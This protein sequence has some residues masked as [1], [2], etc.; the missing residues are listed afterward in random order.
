MLSFT[1][2]MVNDPDETVFAGALTPA[3]IFSAGSLPPL[4]WFQLGH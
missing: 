3:K 4:K 1:V 2:H